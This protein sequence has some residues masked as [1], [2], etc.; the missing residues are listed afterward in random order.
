MQF[1]YKNSILSAT[2]PEVYPIPPV[3]P[4]V[5]ISQLLN[6]PD[7]KMTITLEHMTIVHELKPNL[8]RELV[9]GDDEMVNVSTHENPMET[10]HLQ[11]VV[12]SK[13]NPMVSKEM[14]FT[15]VDALKDAAPLC[16]VGA[17]K[18]PEIEQSFRKILDD[19]ASIPFDS[20]QT[21][22]THS[23]YLNKYQYVRIFDNGTKSTGG[24]L[25]VRFRETI[26]PEV[27]FGIEK[28]CFTSDQVEVWEEEMEKYFANLFLQRNQMHCGLLRDRFKKCLTLTCE[29]CHETFD[30]PLWTV[31]LKDH[32]N[33]QHMFDKPWGCVKCRREWS[34]FQLLQMDWKHEC[35][36][37][38][39]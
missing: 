27:W 21:R 37:E 11:K 32:I 4:D 28:C 18:V 19:A 34:Q 29:R 30:G 24:D 16:E 31:K 2:V 6:W 33:R 22:I 39:G 20:I 17:S 13:V 10:R 3:F 26:N 25:K 14:F 15:Y 12:T 23:R 1:S 8:E 36:T 38:S 7:I 5:S 35:T 9:F